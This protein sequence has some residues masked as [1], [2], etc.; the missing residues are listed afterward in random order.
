LD[1]QALGGEW[2]KR[3]VI[4]MAAMACGFGLASA[5]AADPIVAKLQSP[6]EGSK[7][8]VAG[9]AIFS[10]SDNVCVAKNPVGSTASLTACRDLARKVGALSMFGRE[11]KPFESNKLASCNASAKH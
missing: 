11:A 10:C 3:F 1:R 6:V 4:A 8:Y 7:R 5:W 2:M 9:D